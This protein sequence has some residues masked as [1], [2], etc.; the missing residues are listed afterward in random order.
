MLGNGERRT[1]PCARPRDNTRRPAR[2]SR[3]AAAQDRARLQQRRKAPAGAR[4]PRSARSPST[5]QPRCGA[6]RPGSCASAAASSTRAR[7]AHH[8]LVGAL[9][10]LLPAMRAAVA[11]R[12][13]RSS[14]ARMRAPHSAASRHHPCCRPSTCMA[15]LGVK[16]ASVASPASARR[17]SASRPEA[18]RTSAETCR[19]S[20][21]SASHTRARSATDAPG[22]I[23]VGIAQARIGS[24]IPEGARA[25]RVDRSS[26]S[27]CRKALRQQAQR[28]R[29]ARSDAQPILPV[30]V[31]LAVAAEAAGA[32]IDR[33][34]HGAPAADQRA[35]GA[36]GGPAADHDRDV[37]G[38]AAHVGDDEI[39]SSPVRNPAPTTLAAG[40]DRMVSTGYSSATS[41][42]ISEPSPL[43]IMSGASI[44]SSASTRDSASMRWRICGVRRAFSTAVSAR[45][46][47][48][49]FELS[50]CAQVTGFLR[51][52]ADDLA[53]A[54]FVRRVAHGKIRRH[55][56]RLDARV[57]HRSPRARRPP[58][59]AR[60]AFLAGAPM[61]AL[62]HAHQRA[63]AVALPRPER[64]T[65]ASSKPIRSV[66][67]GLKRFSTTA[68]V[69]SV[70]DTDTR[71]TSR[72]A[73]AAAA[74]PRAPR[75]CALPIPIARFHGVVS[76]LALAM[77]RRPPASS[78]ASVNVPPVSSPSQR[79]SIGP[80]EICAFICLD[81][82]PSASP[83]GRV[84][85]H[86]CSGA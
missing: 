83:P 78:T 63:A 35:L 61:A 1:E 62:I 55:G 5:P 51:Q 14:V 37:G 43:T 22:A 2:R 36:D 77:T 21:A 30:E 67:T 52:R 26:A 74:M 49:S 68:L 58:R 31:H 81:T 33:L 32:H 54:Q 60:V 20:S 86:C 65:M 27:D 7:L 15:S 16:A 10:D 80:A 69:A 42:L 19:G 84:T 85:Y 38:G 75:E 48:S 29:L 70:V 47:A 8:V 25:R 57:V 9:A 11:A 3:P 82:P 46:G 73:R 39:R 34:D 71:L 76:A 18:L 50:S 45:R 12:A 59:R 23:A 13:L 6:S 28:H 24:R 40:P 66:H 72:A 44:D 41:A 79:P 64:S 4:R 53:R 56:E 17:R